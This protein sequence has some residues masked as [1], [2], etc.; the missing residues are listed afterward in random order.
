MEARPLLSVGNQARGCESGN[1]RRGRAIK[2]GREAHVPNVLKVHGPSVPAHRLESH[3]TAFELSLHILENE[4]RSVIQLLQGSL[5]MSPGCD[6]SSVLTS[7]LVTIL[8]NHGD[9]TWFPRSDP[10]RRRPILASDARDHRLLG[11]RQRTRSRQARATPVSV[12]ACTRW[13]GLNQ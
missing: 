3:L 4:S 13:S 10:I 7:L 1:K 5:L 11:L 6:L 2:W 9:S 12:R 8:Q